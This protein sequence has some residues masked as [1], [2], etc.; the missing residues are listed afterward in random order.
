MIKQKLFFSRSVIKTV[1]VI[2]IH[3]VN[4]LQILRTYFQSF[5]RNYRKPGIV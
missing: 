2:D 3:D 1:Y 5:N 4:N